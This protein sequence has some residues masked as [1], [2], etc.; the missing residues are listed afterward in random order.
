MI[1]INHELK[2]VFIHIPKNG[3]SYVGSTLEKYYHF[4]NYL[5]LLMK[6]R[7]DHHIICKTSLDSRISKTGNY[8]YDNSFFN[9]TVGLLVYCK[10]SKYLSEK[11]NMNEEKWNTY[12]KFTFIRNPYSRILSGWKHFNTVFNRNISLNEYL[13]TEN[14]NKLSNI[15][16]GH[17]IMTQKKQIENIDASCGVDIIGRFEHLEEDLRHILNYLGIQTIKHPIEHINVSNTETY[18][19]IVF[20]STAIQFINYWFRED[21][22]TF[23]YQMVE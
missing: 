9:R 1:Y 7:P 10:T 6:R 11:M 21:F 16:Y 19:N 20:E 22:N 8:I 5:P 23:H 2:A 14:V 15:E 3:G 12:T 4:T 18:D 13:Q 17:T